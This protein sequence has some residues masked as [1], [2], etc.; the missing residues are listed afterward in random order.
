M[1][2]PL[3]APAAAFPAASHPMGTS[4]TSFT[5]AAR[6]ACYCG[7]SQPWNQIRTGVPT[8][9]IRDKFRTLLNI[10]VKREAPTI[11]AK[12]RMGSKI[13]LGGMRMFITST[14]P[15]ELW[16]FFSLQGW[17]EVT[18]PRDRRKYMD[19]PRASFDL[20]ARCNS[21]EREMRYRQLVGA[22]QRKRAAAQGVCATGAGGTPRPPVR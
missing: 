13:T 5:A 10:R 18:H 6:L 8:T 17:R 12:P 1:P 20:L 21:S 9:V 7:G 22:L 2:M 16:Y 11:G 14:P 4:E 3:P 19:L 15:D